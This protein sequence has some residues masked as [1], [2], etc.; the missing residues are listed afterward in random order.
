LPADLQRDL[1]RTPADWLAHI[2]RLLQQG[3]RQEALQ[4]L[5]LFR[6]THPDQPVPDDLR[7][8]P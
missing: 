1:H 2:R 6:R 5:D 4:S 3:Q 7:T 8:L